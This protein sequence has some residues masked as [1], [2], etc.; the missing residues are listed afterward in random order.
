[1]VAVT[2]KKLNYEENM[3][4]SVTFIGTPSDV[5]TALATHAS[6]LD[7]QSKIEYT[8]A[9]PFML[10]LTYQNYE[11]TSSPKIKLAANGHGYAENNVQKSRNFSINLSRYYG[12]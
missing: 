7:G 1:M 6:S 11:P 2:F 4:W 9:L 8:D 5:A 12:E 10:A 3:S